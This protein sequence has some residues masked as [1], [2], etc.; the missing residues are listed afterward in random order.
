MRSVHEIDS[1]HGPNNKAGP[2]NS[3][4]GTPASKLQRIRLKLSQPSKEPGTD[5]EAHN[6][7]VLTKTAIVDA[8]D[9]EDMTMP[10][11][12]PELGFDHHELAMQPRD[13][14]RLLRRQITWAEQETAQL[15]T[16]WD[17]IRLRREHAWQEKEAIFDDVID[18]ELRLFS[19]IVGDVGA[20]AIPGTKLSTSLEKLQQQQQQFKQQQEHLQGK[21]VEPS[22]AH[23]AA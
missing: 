7:P 16:A 9:P 1:L 14:Y 4:A 3:V 10:E 6:E 5:T 8:T 2:A 19:A 18:G 22:D 21:T 15:R 11:Y 17:N 13:L 12:G 20:S 23:A